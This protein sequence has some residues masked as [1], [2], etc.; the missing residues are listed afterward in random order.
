MSRVSAALRTVLAFG[1]GRRTPAIAGVAALAVSL[2]PLAGCT[3]GMKGEGSSYLMIRGLEC[4]SGAKPTELGGTCNSDVLTFVKQQIN[5]QEVRVP[6][7]FEDLGEVTL[8]LGMKN[9]ALE[10]TPT[11]F[12]TVNRYRVEYVRADGRNTPGVDVPYPFD[13]ALT[14]TI[15]DDA[16]IATFNIVRIQ[17]KMENPLKPLVGAGGALSISTLAKITFY[18][19]DQSGRETTVTGQIGINFADWGD[20]D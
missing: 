12:I 8:E 4:A 9:P 5:G 6:T 15:T 7:I 14:L 2:A 3:S 20:P 10:P 1:Q 16:G 17:A 13:G 18:G 11:N 19:Y